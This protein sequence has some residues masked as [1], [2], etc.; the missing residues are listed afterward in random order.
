MPVHEHVLTGMSLKPS[1]RFDSMDA[2]LQALASEG[3]TFLRRLRRKFPD[4]REGNTAPSDTHDER[5][6]R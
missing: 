6:S 2:L 3:D 5:P 1:Q 4:D